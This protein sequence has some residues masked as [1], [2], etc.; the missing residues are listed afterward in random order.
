MHARKAIVIGLA[1]A[2]GTGVA[3]ALSRMNRAGA[4]G[5]R[6]RSLLARGSGGDERSAIEEFTC[7]CGQVFRVTGSG[8]HRVYWVAGAAEGDP[9]LGHECPNCERP[10]PRD[11]DVAL[12]ATGAANGAI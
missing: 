10:L 8:R 9:V 5:Q 7:D 11:Q 4:A 6:V 12:A 2:A 1:G 3:Y